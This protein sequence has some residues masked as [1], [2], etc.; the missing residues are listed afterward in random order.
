MSRHD[1]A[2]RKT[3]PLISHRHRQSVEYRAV[4]QSIMT[5]RQQLLQAAGARIGGAAERKERIHRRQIGRRGQV[6]VVAGL[7]GL[8]QPRNV[9]QQQPMVEV[10]L[11][12]ATVVQ[13]EHGQPP[14]VALVPDGQIA[15]AELRLQ[16]P[17]AARGVRRLL[18]SE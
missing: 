6:I 15:D 18:K 4:R 13:I 16:V 9:G 7:K 14:V 10:D 5:A 17:N 11:R 1:N 2:N 3:A 12:R 8:L